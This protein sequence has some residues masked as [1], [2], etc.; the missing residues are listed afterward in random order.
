[1]C[2]GAPSR[3][4]EEACMRAQPKKILV[5][6][7]AGYVGSVLVDE[8][9]RRGYPV[10]VFDRLIYGDGGLAEVRDRVDL[11]VGDMRAM[12]ASVFKDVS[13]VINLG[14][15]SNDPTAE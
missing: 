15:I 10:R 12:D 13:A 4:L 1:M 5:I 14:G 2:A 9:L 6:G 7:G 3:A 11:V 8:L